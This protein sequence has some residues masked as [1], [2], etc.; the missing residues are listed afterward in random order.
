MNR[1]MA[2]IPAAFAVLAPCDVK[3]QALVLGYP[4]G[5]TFSFYRD[6]DGE[7]VLRMFSQPGQ[8]GNW[9]ITPAVSGE[10]IKI[11]DCQINDAGDTILAIDNLGAN[12]V[13]TIRAA[14][15][16][17]TSRFN[18][19]PVDV[20]GDV[21][22]VSVW[23]IGNMEAGGDIVGPIVANTTNTTQGITLVQSGDDILGS[24][25]APGGRI[26]FVLSGSDIGTSSTAVTIEAL[27]YIQRIDGDNVYANI[28]CGQ[29]GSGNGYLSGLT[30]INL[31]GEVR[32][33]EVA[34]TVGIDPQWA[35]TNSC[36]ADIFIGKSFPSGSNRFIR[37][38][39]G[40]LTYK[41]VINAENVGGATW[42]APVKLGTDSNPAQVVLTSPTY[43]QTS[44]QLGGGSVGLAPFRIHATD[45]DPPSGTSQSVT[46][47][48]TVVLRFYGPVYW[49]TGSP[50]TVY[51]RDAQSPG[52]WEALSGGY[53]MTTHGADPRDIIV[54]ATTEEDFSKIYDYRIVPTSNLKCDEV[55]GNPSVS[56]A[57]EYFLYGQ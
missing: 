42:S 32:V 53:Y 3:A 11:I 37:L 24:V 13:H 46:E 34:P 29:T 51:W 31:T 44:S 2:C 38:P 30:A 22:S 43:T 25:R 33:R 36:N 16:T 49:T 4:S 48:T 23:N 47:T 26:G 6:T 40:G 28:H 39:V 15:Q 21:G 35:I 10:V 18:L 27:N 12:R 19:G 20:A 1:F 9:S 5:A 56:T 17:G 45:C 7:W 55:N 41:I 54:T 50:V 57:V 14:A 52:A 8:G